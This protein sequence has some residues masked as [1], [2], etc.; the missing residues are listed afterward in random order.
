[1]Q[2]A[3][4]IA[5]RHGFLAGERLRAG[6]RLVKH[7]SNKVAGRGKQTRGSTGLGRPR[8]MLK[9]HR[10][11]S[12]YKASGIRPDFPF[13]LQKRGATLAC[14]IL[15]LIQPRELETR[16]KLPARIMTVACLSPPFVKTLGRNPRA[17]F[18]LS[19]SGVPTPAPQFGVPIG[20]VGFVGT[21]N[22]CV[23][24]GLMVRSPH[25]PPSP[26][27]FHLSG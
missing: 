10:R 22:L 4:G 3:K 2:P 19:E 21:N 18:M 5:R 9:N 7:V 11:D 27:Y 25:A 13:S 20:F 26:P 8:G 24:N 23:C 1:V 12:S 6:H 14:I 16:M 15:P 17:T